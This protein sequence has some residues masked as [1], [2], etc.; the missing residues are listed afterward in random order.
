MPFAEDGGV[1]MSA[2]DIRAQ[3][4]T[5][6]ARWAQLCTAFLPSAPA[7]S[8]WRYSREDE[9]ADPEQ[10]WKLHISATVLT[11]GRVFEAVAPFLRRRGVLFKAPASLDELSKLNSGL[12]YGYSQVGKF[13]TVYPRTDAE[14]VRLAQGLHRLTRGLSGPNIPFDLQYRRDSPIHYRYGAFKT[15]ELQHADGQR[16]FAIRDPS[17]QLVPDVRDSA[18][19]PEWVA[20]PFPPERKTRR[21]DSS[22]SPLKTTFR[23]FRALAQRGKG[24]VYQ[25]LDWS[26]R[27]PRLCV[28]KEGRQGGEVDWLGRDGF[29]RVRHEGHVLTNLR[30]V[31][32]DVP[33]VYTEFEAEGNYYIA[34]EFV[35]GDDLESWLARKRHR[36]PLVI[37]LRHAAALAELLAR[38]HAAGWVWRDC[39]PR[40]IILTE[41]RLRPIDFEGACP[42][43]QSDPLPWGT[44]SYIPPE[45]D[46]EREGQSRLPEDLYALGVTL[47]LLLAGRTPDVAPA[48]R[49]HRL[50]RSIPPEVRAIVAELLDPDPRR[51]P[52]ARAAARRLRT[53]LAAS[54]CGRPTARGGAARARR[55]RL[56]NGEGAG[57]RLLAAGR[58][59]GAKIHAARKVCVSRVGAEVVEQR[60]D[61]QAD[62]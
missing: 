31:G 35:E 13:I 22:L 56:E 38:I 28:L 23:A 45:W 9:A 7:D 61:R 50:R 37:C 51:R 25:A 15:I 43:A 60:L 53:A 47:Y 55:P 21:R 14:A 41:G 54:D 26:A 16:T 17:G 59:S 5:F 24:G 20:D 32:I 27:P 42:V 44:P 12:Y 58:E 52:G 39:K 11:A 40:N 3:R 46:E 30:A 48:S 57:S 6:D 62:E 4:A 33:Q 8:I 36:L 18:A 10:G 19:L 2:A 34:V 1:Q 29:W 49:L